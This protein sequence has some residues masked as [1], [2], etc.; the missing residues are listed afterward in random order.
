MPMTPAA[1]ERFLAA[2]TTARPVEHRKMFG[3][4]GLYLDG[5]FMGVMDDDRLYLKADEQTE[6]GYVAAGMEAWTLPQGPQPY[7][8]VPPNALDDPQALGQ[9]LDESRQAA[10]RRRAR[11][12]HKCAKATGTG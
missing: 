8:E 4:V 5:V 11:P 10:L 1:T 2:L 12:T 9:L 3:G 7:R 6:P